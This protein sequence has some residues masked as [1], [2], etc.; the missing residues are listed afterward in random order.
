MKDLLKQLSTKEKIGQL[1]QI[2]PFF[3]VKDL[4]K[5]VSGPVEDLHLNEELIFLAGSVLG[6]GSP[7]EMILVQKTYLEKSRHKIPLIFMADIIHGYKTIFPVPIALASSWN[8]SLLETV[9]RI[10]ALEASTSGI[11]VTF[12]PMADLSRDPRWGRVVEGF[13]EDPYLTGKYAEAMVRGYQ[14]DGIEKVG[15]LAS[16][17]KHFAGY[18]ASESGRDYNTVDL[19]RQTLHDQYF[20]GYKKAIDAG[21][22]LVMTAFNVI[23]GVPSTANK[24]LL[25][26]VLRDTWNFK[27]VTISDYDSLKQIIAHG[28]AEDMEE[29]A[30]KGI[31][32]GL[33]IEMSSSAYSNHLETLIQKKQVQMSLLDEA[34]LRILEL[35][36]DLGLFENPFKGIENES[37]KNLVLSLSHLEAS[38]KVAH[39]SMVLLKNEDILPLT[40]GATL[41]LIGPYSTSRATVGPWSWHGRR[42]T[43]TT[44]EEAL[45]KADQR[46]IFVKDSISLLDYTLKDIKQIQRA[47]VVIVAIGENERL[48]GEA[49]SLSDIHLPSKQDLLVNMVKALG[50]KVL[51]ILF[52]G[53]PLLLE[54]ILDADAIL[55]TWFLGSKTAEAITDV[56]TGKINPSG[57]LPMSFPKSIGQIPIYY[58][59]LNTGRPY[60]GPN[61]DNEFVSR[62]LDVS[63]EP[64]FPFGFG[65]SYLKLTYKDLRLDKLKITSQETLHASITISNDST[66]EGF[67][68][69]E[70]YIRDYTASI[71]RP[72]KELKQFKKIWINR[73][74]TLT[75][76]F[77]ITINDLMYTIDDGSKTYEMGRFCLMIGP[78]SNT[79]LQK[80]FW[81]N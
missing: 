11:H 15:S 1:L 41:A 35:K 75:V 51:V 80:D 63:N 81:L 40:K 52:N 30:L 57:K 37:M 24:Y 4:K 7:E 66:F 5:E 77:D 9:A 78:S 2:A 50:K 61:D 67:E 76:T 46:L 31:T 38:L 22:R 23:D 10:S 34:V 59:H 44:L 3:F 6:V 79:V 73:H 39:E 33:D 27:G 62:Y 48:S 42:D 8:P 54:N 21:A 55:E 28:Y 64:L 13:G 12:S 58:N 36:K 68:I 71:C 25:R 60:I 49:H 65:L 70:V 29:V 18:G 43:N 56:L 69:V 32:A 16:C 53:R 14:N 72:V 47:D 17:V 26:D 45:I 20:I 74:S 19:S